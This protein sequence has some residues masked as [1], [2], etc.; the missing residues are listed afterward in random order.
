MMAERL[1]DSIVGW[2]CN[3]AGRQQN[4]FFF[5]LSANVKFEKKTPV[6]HGGT[7]DERAGYM[8]A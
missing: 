5:S 1:F 2:I 8:L 3:T 6:Y 7:E 4:D